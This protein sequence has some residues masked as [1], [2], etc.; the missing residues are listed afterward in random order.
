MSP[1]ELL[2]YFGSRSKA[3][4]KI[5]V[6]YQAVKAWEDDGRVPNL[7]QHHIEN[8]TGGVLKADETICAEAV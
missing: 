1:K 4:K 7:R 8:I 3:A 5:G 2:D 6:S